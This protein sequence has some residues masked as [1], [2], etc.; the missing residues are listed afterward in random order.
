MRFMER[1]Y[2]VQALYDNL[3][4]K[5]KVLTSSCIM[6]VESFCDGASVETSDGSVFYGDI[7]IGADGVHSRVRAEMQR[8][9]E[10]ESPGIDLFPEKD[11]GSLDTFYYSPTLIF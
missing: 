1:R 11:G 9:A 3:R 6:K 2:A 4:D 5:S 10:K 8:C 7:V